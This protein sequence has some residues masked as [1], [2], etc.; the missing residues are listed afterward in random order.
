MRPFGCGLFIREFLMGHGPY[1]TP[2]LTLI[3]AHRSSDTY[4]VTI[5]GSPAGY[6]AG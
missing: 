1:E 2:R 5:N 6:S 4:V 3:L